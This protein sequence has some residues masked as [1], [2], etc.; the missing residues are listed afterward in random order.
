MKDKMNSENYLNQVKEEPVDDDV[1]NDIFDFQN[2]LGVEESNDFFVSSSIWSTLV[3]R[4]RFLLQEEHGH[5]NMNSYLIAEILIKETNELLSE[6]VKFFQDCCNPVSQTKDPSESILTVDGLLVN[7]LPCHPQNLKCSYKICTDIPQ[8]Y[9]DTLFSPLPNEIEGEDQFDN[10]FLPLAPN[11]EIGIKEE[12]NADVKV[13]RKSKLPKSKLKK[14]HICDICG[15][16]FKT[17]ERYRVHVSG[18]HEKKKP[19]KCNK[20][21]L[22]YTYINGL[23]FHK[24]SGNCSG[25]PK[26]EN[27]WIY[28]GT[29]GSTD[30]KCLHPDCVNIELPR[31]TYAGIFNHIMD[32]HS[33]DP[34]DSVSFFYYFLDGFTHL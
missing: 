7:C 2:Q 21:G 8:T 27:K 3:S 24:K 14:E 20:C 26:N 1:K 4:C 30:P 19:F 32:V 9:L 11:V 34:D 23:R 6:I 33:P 18:V 28:W 25:E 15:K 5:I 16:S 10:D 17:K 22:A 29:T 13:E 31:F 12:T